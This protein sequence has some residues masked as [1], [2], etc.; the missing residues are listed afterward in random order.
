M[1]AAVAR[2]RKHVSSRS[3]LRELQDWRPC[4][5]LV[6]IARLERDG[7]SDTSGLHTALQLDQLD[8]QVDRGAQIGMVLLEPA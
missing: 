4:E 3:N 6:E 5:S 8:L 2:T 7:G 1:A